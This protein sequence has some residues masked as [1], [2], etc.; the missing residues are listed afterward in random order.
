MSGFDY[1]KLALTK[2][3]ANFEGRSR[4]SEYW[5]FV[6]FQLIIVYGLQALG[7][8]AGSELLVMAS[9]IPSL[10][11]LIPG[12]SVAVRRLHDVDKSGWFLLLA[13]IPLLGTIYLLYLFAKEGTRGP[14]R[15]GL[16]PKGTTSNSL[17]DNLI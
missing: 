17:T 14:N 16:D 8:L 4:R 7:Y 2:N 15:F 3:F 12:I 9:L 13:F 6:L 5:Y 1:F 10:L 11:F